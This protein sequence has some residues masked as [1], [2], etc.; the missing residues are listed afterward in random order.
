MPTPINSSTTS[1][2]SYRAQSANNQ[3]GKQISSLAS[4]LKASEKIAKAV[5]ADTTGLQ[6]ALQR[7]SG[8][9]EQA[10]ASTK[11]SL[12][13]E[14]VEKLKAERATATASTARPEKKQFASVD[15]AIAYG[16]SRAAEQA[17]ARAT[18]KTNKPNEV[19][20]VASNSGAASTKRPERKQ[21][22][23]VDEAISYGASR[24]A[25]QANTRPTD[26]STKPSETSKVNSQTEA[27]STTTTRPERRQFK[28]VD[29][30]IT[31]GAQRAVEQYS[32][33]QL[34]LGSATRGN[35]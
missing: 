20:A 33:Q 18:D 22:S 10:N 26:T 24:A 13:S 35:A 17:N 16:A 1:Q 19:S 31:Y 4:S 11:V 7:V 34:A 5:G 12:S 3:N 25:E 15:E 30:A 23:S 8:N 14:G 28:S 9:Q 32:K 6:N 21:F 27:A 29:E 2:D